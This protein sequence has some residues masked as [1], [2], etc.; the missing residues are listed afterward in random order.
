[1]RLN[2]ETALSTLTWL[3]VNEEWEYNL[4]SENKGMRKV[5]LQEEERNLEL[6]ND[7]IWHVMCV[8]CYCKIAGV[9]EL[10]VEE[11]D[12]CGGVIIDWWLKLL[13]A[14]ECQTLDTNGDSAHIFYIN[15]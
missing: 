3:G 12:Y 11:E 7:D 5:E 9:D 6:K 1:M 2:E 14:Q 15:K 13:L 8:F 10:I 4:K